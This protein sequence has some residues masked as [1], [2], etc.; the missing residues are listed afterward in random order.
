MFLYYYQTNLYQES[1]SSI[2]VYML[3]VLFVFIII[4][5]MPCD[6]ISLRVLIGLRFTAQ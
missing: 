3:L 1:Y 4:N 6:L 5:F 2:S